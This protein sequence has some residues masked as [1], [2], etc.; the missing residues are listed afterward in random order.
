MSMV[1]IVRYTRRVLNLVKVV[2]LE[3]SH[4]RCSHRAEDTIFLQVRGKDA[5]E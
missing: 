2:E 5:S 3:Y 1:K 4:L